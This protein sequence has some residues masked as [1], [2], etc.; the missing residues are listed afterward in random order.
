MLGEKKC[1]VNS[2]TLMFARLTGEKHHSECQI[3]GEQAGGEPK[4]ITSCAVFSAAERAVFPHL[5]PDPIEKANEEV[6][7][8]PGRPRLPDLPRRLSLQPALLP[9]LV[10]SSPLL[11]LPA[12]VSLTLPAG[13][14][15]IPG[16]A[17]PLPHLLQPALPQKRQARHHCSGSRCLSAGGAQ[18]DLPRR[19][20]GFLL[21]LR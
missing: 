3:D 20:P 11:P 5:H 2:R 13:A 4:R 12:R 8:Q 17:L 14:L 1:A 10:G 7:V 18:A 19:P 9:S 6:V 21:L 15:L 16:R